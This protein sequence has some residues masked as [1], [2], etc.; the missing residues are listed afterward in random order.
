MCIRDRF[1]GVSVPSPVVSDAKAFKVD[2]KGV[3]VDVKGV[4]VDVKG[5]D[6]GLDTGVRHSQMEFCL[7]L[8]KLA[9]NVRLDPLNVHLN[10]LN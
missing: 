8:T 10:P 3:A 5:V 9:L 6:K 1:Y 4:K 2:V 7:A